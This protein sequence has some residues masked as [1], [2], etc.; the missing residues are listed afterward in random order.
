MKC[1]NLECTRS[2]G[3]VAHR[4][5]WFDNRRYCSKQCRDTFAAERPRQS[6]KERWGTSYFEWLFVQPI[7]M[8]QLKPAVV[9]L[10]TRSSISAVRRL[11]P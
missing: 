7:E 9:R 5:G 10:R 4:R 2:F 8:A 3:L 11:R 1:S 6:Q